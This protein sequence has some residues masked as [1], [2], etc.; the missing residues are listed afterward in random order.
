ML[1][2]NSKIIK[3][4]GKES[5]CSSRILDYQWCMWT[6]GSFF[7]S[8]PNCYKRDHKFP[9]I[10]LYDIAVYH[11]IFVIFMYSS[12]ITLYCVVSWFVCGIPSML[13]EA[14]R[15]S[16]YSLGSSHLYNMHCHVDCSSVPVFCCCIV[17]YL[18]Y[19]SYCAFC[20]VTLMRAPEILNTQIC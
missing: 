15:V 14:Y 7:A 17:F 10:K 16:H 18:E 12:N 2:L 13:L 5:W 1:N 3:M 20:I 4:L 19:R 9:F 11:L 8:F 6:R